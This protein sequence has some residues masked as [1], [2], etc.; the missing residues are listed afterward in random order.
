MTPL[1]QS[2]P[3]GRLGHSLVLAGQ[4]TPGASLI[5]VGGYAENYFYDDLWFYNLTTNKWLQ[6]TYYTHAELPPTCLETTTVRERATGGARRES[7]RPHVSA[8]SHHKRSI[9]R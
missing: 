7:V 8:P 1:S 6:K 9:A 5:L 4:G 3:S 2:K